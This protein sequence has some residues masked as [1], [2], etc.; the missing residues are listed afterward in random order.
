[1]CERG[2]DHEV[3]SFASMFAEGFALQPERIERRIKKEKRS[4]LTERQRK[5]GAVRTAQINFRCSPAFKLLASDLAAH[6]DA[7]I[8]DL[9]EEALAMLARAKNFKE[10]Q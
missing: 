1:M 7:S 2:D 9:M 10:G 3:E 6:C 4:V 5:R 8:A